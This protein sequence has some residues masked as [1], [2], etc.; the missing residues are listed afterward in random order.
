MIRAARYPQHAPSIDRHEKELI[1]WYCS[2]A[3]FRRDYRVLRTCC[4]SLSGSTHCS[5]PT[6]LLSSSF[7]LSSCDTVVGG[8]HFR[9]DLGLS[10]RSKLVRP[11]SLRVD[12]FAPP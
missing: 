9:I 5:G 11:V 2:R 4:G 8:R 1:Q 3:L 7:A 12:R 10:I 6:L